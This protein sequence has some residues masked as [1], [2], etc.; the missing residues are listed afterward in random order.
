MCDIN[1][2]LYPVIRLVILGMPDDLSPARIFLTGSVSYFQPL[3]LTCRTMSPKSTHSFTSRYT[4]LQLII[5]LLHSHL[6]LAGI[7]HFITKYQDNAYNAVHFL[8]VDHRSGHAYTTCC[9][10]NSVR[11]TMCA[12]HTRRWCRHAHTGCGKTWENLSQGLPENCQVNMFYAE[13]HI[14]YLGT[15]QGMFNATSGSCRSEWESGTLTGNI[16]GV[17]PGDN[18]LYA[19]SHQIG[20]CRYRSSTGKWESMSANLA[21]QFVH[22]I[23]EIGEGVLLAG[24]ESGLYPGGVGEF[25]PWDTIRQTTCSVLSPGMYVIRIHG[26]ARKMIKQ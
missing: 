5:N 4:L 17:F 16:T 23:L 26:K 15:G 3:T 11:T 12:G 21:D 7:V 9:A 14:S 1:W 8:A 24:C 2:N 18:G 13:E 19:V 6:Y 10:H 25:L 22:V 20:F